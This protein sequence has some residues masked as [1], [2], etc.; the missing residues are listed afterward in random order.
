MTR[1]TEKCS[2]T[3]VT[4]LYRLD[5]PLIAKHAHPGQFVIVRV[6]ENGERIPL[7]IADYDRAAGTITI[8]VQEVG[9]TTR[10]LGALEVGQHILDV[11][12]PLGMALDVPVSGHV[13]IGGIRQ[14]RCV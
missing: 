4:N 11:V 9:A 13:W 6:R 12:G 3:P 1:I 8:V 10:D 7:T 2:L 5:A 14:W